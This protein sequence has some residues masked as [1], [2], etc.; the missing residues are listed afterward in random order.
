MDEMINLNYDMTRDEE[1]AI[2]SIAWS[3]FNAPE[4]QI[5]EGNV[6]FTYRFRCQPN[7]K[8]DLM[9]RKNPGKVQIHGRKQYYEL[10]NG[11]NID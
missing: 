9:N 8:Q 4:Y 2:N 3:W 6:N 11:F 5:S 1:N 10:S 7:K